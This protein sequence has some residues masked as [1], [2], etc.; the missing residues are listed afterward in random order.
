MALETQTIDEEIASDWAAIQEKYAVEPEAK[1]PESAEPETP[2]AERARDESGKFVAREEPTAKPT[3]D[4]A[5]VSAPAP[6]KQSAAPI[7]EAGTPPATPAEGGAEKDV[8]RAPSTWK[9]TARAE[10]DKLPPAIKAEIH[11]REA[12]FMSGHNQLLPDAKFGKSVNEIIAPYRMLI[13]AEGG[14]PE[15][16]IADLMRT[17][18]VL[19]MG[20]PQQKQQLFMQVAKQYGVDLNVFAQQPGQPETAQSFQDPRVDQLLAQMNHEREANVQREQQALEA[21]VNTWMNEVDAQGQPLRPYIGD[22]ITEVSALVPQ[23]RQQQPSLSHP[24]VLQ[25]AYDRAI[26]AH[27]EIRTLLQKQQAQT[28]EQ[29]RVTDNQTRVR[30]ARRA[31]SVNVPRRASISAPGKPGKLEDT[32]EQTAREL[33]LIS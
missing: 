30:E 28:N 21:S 12:D 32:I 5:K 33:G 4:A 17:A 26:W 9:P 25:A 15:R 24:Q 23:I 18:A 20:T 3:A 11:R 13:E 1:E 2:I 27:P 8:T 10:W 7:G 22:V 19:R 16:A 14:T 6:A 31:A 29:A